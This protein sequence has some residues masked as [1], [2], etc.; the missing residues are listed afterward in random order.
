MKKANLFIIGLISIF[1]FGVVSA[2]GATW[3]V[4]K[5][6]NSND[7]V[8][9]AD[10]SLREAVAVSNSGDLIVFN[11]N[12]IGQTF[13]LGGSP[14]AYVGKRIE[15]DGNIDGVNVA[16]ISGSNNTYHFN[17]RD[18]G[19]LTLRNI[20]LVNGNHGSRGSIFAFDANLNLDRVSI[21]NN[22]SNNVGA[23]ELL[24]NT[25]KT[26]SIRNSSITSN[27]TT[28]GGGLQVAAIQVSAGAALYMSN[29]TVSNNRTLGNTLPN[30]DFGAIFAYGEG[31]FLRNC[32]ITANE[33]NYGGG[34]ALR[35]DNPV[36]TFEVGNSIIAGNSAAVAGQDIHFPVPTI[37]T[38]SN[39]GNLIG[40]TD[41]IPGGIFVQTNDAVNL[42]PLLAPTNSNQG[43]HPIFTHPLQA[44]SPALNTG[45]NSVAV[46]PLGNIPLTNDG[47]GTG[48]PRISNGTVD[49]GA[50]EDQSNGATLIVTKLANGN[51]GVCDLDCSLREAVAAANNDAGTDNITMAANVFG[52]FDLGGGEIFIQNNDVNIIGYP[53]LTAETLIASGNNTNRIFRINNSDVSISGMTLANG[54]GV[55]AVSSGFGGAIYAHGG[56][57]LTLDKVI[58]RNNQASVYGAVYLLGGTHRIVNSTINNNQAT[59]CIAVGNVNGTLNMANATISTNLDS[60]SGSGA[61][62]LCNIGATANIRNST[63]AFNRIGSDPGAGIWS[64]GTLNIGNTIVS[65]N[66]AG[67]NPDINNVS[68]TVNSLGGNLIQNPNG[69]N[70]SAI[71]AEGDQTNVDPMLAVLSDNG[72]NVPT[73]LLQASSPAINGG[74]NSVAIDPFDNSVLANDA[75]GVGFSRIVST[76]DK[77]AF[78][79]LIPTAASATV[80]GR[81]TN[82][83]SGV[84]N[85]QVY[86][87]GQNGMLKTVTTNSLGYFSFDE[88][89]VGQT[90]IVSATAKSYQFNSRVVNV[91]EE[92]SDLELVA[93]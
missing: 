46:H 68:G 75:R 34:I 33:G 92:I 18:E 82:G 26:H 24:S 11:S 64:N 12:L 58:V 6:T 73:H 47:R 28:G 37:N 30:A 20:T 69:S 41:T 57:N 22:T 14:I 85:A 89:Q 50:F 13:T 53:T 72:G 56:T 78:E 86:I 2:N 3:T 55:G 43:G 49:K 8:C 65:N 1:I 52:T 48:Y 15:I 21:R 44:G 32:T 10:C 39:G 87:S 23:I 62:A 84:P 77:G 54:N 9:N 51:D 90:Y 83:K 5:S 31:L 27:T 88:I 61:G 19:A 66:I 60:D 80:S 71:N 35:N 67:S 29:T 93:N 59:N 70:L 42:N 4:T 79:T 63:I 16:Q 76:V 17:V 25:P 45:I 38:I 36:Y 7:G 74:L 40:D 91:M 81:V